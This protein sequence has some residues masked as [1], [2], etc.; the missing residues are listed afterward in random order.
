MFKYHGRLLFQG[1]DLYTSVEVVEDPP[2]RLL[3]FGTSVSQSSMYL[4]NPYKIEMEYNQ[5]MLLSLIYNPTPKKV[6][7]LGLGA[8]AKQKFIWKHFSCEVH[9]VELSPLVIE[10]GYRFF[11]IPRDPKMIIH[12]TDAVQFLRESEEV[13]FDFI[14][15]DLYDANGMA[16]VVGT[17]DFFQLC[18]N[19]LNATGVL[20]WNLWRQTDEKLMKSTINSLTQAFEAPY[21]ILTVEESLNLV[22][23]TFASNLDISLEILKENAAQLSVKTGLDFTSLLNVSFR[24]TQ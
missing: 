12:Q 3:H 16:S 9:S 14:F 21:K 10:V 11:E 5:V 23:Y 24:S 8:G 1:K 18:R 19:K 15:V 4:D 17:S 20:V 22:L 7:F 2:L 13:D 6:L